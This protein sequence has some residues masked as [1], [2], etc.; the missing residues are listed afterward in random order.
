[1]YIEEDGQEA[2]ERNQDDDDEHKSTHN[3]VVGVVES[4]T[5]PHNPKH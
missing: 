4:T 2:M 3:L 5:Q 1:M